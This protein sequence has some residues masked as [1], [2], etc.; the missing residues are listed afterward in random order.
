MNIQWFLKYSVTQKMLLQKWLSQRVPSNWRIY[1]FK[2]KKKG[3]K[4]CCKFKDFDRWGKIHLNH[5]YQIPPY[6]LPYFLP[7]TNP[8]HTCLLENAL[9]FTLF[10]PTT[11]YFFTT[12]IIY[13]FILPSCIL[14]VHPHLCSEWPLLYNHQ[15]SNFNSRLK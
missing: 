6:P 4:E 12:S 3:R 1:I 10:S 5:I 15:K 13:S 2:K 11:I 14:L 9:I 7:T 8:A